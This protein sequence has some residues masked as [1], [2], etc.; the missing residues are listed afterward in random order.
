MPRTSANWHRYHKWT[1]ADLEV[2][3]NMIADGAGW[4]R[5]GGHFGVSAAAAQSTATY[6]GLKA[7]MKQA[8]ENPD[9]ALA[10]VNRPPHL[11]PMEGDFACQE[12]RRE[13]EAAKRE[14]PVSPPFK[15]QGSW[16]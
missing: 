8:R 6:R 5:I 13:I 3:D 12:L 2:M 10:K 16:L 11:V 7:R 15:G 14:R 1:D 4:D 9:P